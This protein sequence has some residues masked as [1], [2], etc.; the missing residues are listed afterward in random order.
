[1]RHGCRRRHRLSGRSFPDGRSGLR[2]S[3]LV[4]AVRHPLVTRVVVLAG[5]SGSGKSRLAD[6]LGLPVL[7]LDDFYREGD[8]PGLP[9]AFGIVDWDDPASWHREAACEAVET[10]CRNGSVEVPNYDIRTSRAVG[11][12]VVDAGG[13]PLVVAEGIFAAETIEPLAAAGVLADAICLTHRP[14]VTFARRLGRDLRESR[15]PPWTLL[16]RGWALMRAEPAIVARQVLLG[17]AACS[18]AEAE[19]RVRTL[20]QPQSA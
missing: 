7:R 5:P 14:V 16:R 1:M 12:Y 13:S 15:K 6:R 18:P 4:P 19:R 9:R 10:L 3:R 2:E 8:D 17:A 11:H 20:L